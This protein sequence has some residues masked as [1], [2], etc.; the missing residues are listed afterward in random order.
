MYSFL[1]VV[2]VVVGFSVLVL[3]P[4]PYRISLMK[5]TRDKFYQVSIKKREVL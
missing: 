4:P 2:V 5:R 3:I 1:V